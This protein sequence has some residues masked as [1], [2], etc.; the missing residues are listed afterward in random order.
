MRKRFKYATTQRR[1]TT[2]FV[3]HTLI[4]VVASILT[5][6]L[7][8]FGKE[9]MTDPDFYAGTLIYKITLAIAPLL[10]KFWPQIE[11][12]IFS[13]SLGTIIPMCIILIPLNIN[14][15]RVIY[16]S[17]TRLTQGIEDI[18]EGKFETRLEAS[19]GG[20]FAHTYE[21]FNKTAEELSNV[22][23]LKNDFINNY[24]HEFKT[25]IS[26]ISGFSKLL[27]EH[28]DLT[29]EE[30]KSYLKIINVESNRLADMANSTIM[31]SKLNNQQIVTDKTEYELDEQLRMCIIILTEEWTKKNIE[32]SSE[33]DSVIYNGNADMMSRLWLNLIGNAVKYTPE[34]GEIEVR[35]KKSDGEI[36]VEISD[37][38]IGMDEETRNRIFDQYYQGETAH[39]GAGLGL[40]LPICKRIV[41]LCGGKITVKSV[42]DEGSTFTVTLPV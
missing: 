8:E 30:I 6:L 32:I 26:S 41:E 14:L 1:I 5:Y 28:D 10:E 2:L 9:V 38:G 25:P 7:V 12:N 29:D 11:N 33:L 17:V 39:S 40:G 20:V 35:L 31:L 24:S 15:S 23:K 16:R 4:I 37:T 13:S 42:P 19:K 3:F 21:S 18:G 27:L 34:N 22:T 36:T